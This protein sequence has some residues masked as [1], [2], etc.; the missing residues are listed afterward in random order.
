M[1]RKY[2]S[3]IYT[4]IKANTN[5]FI[6]KSMNSKY[7]DNAKKTDIQELRVDKLSIVERN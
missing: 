7:L 3:E 2:S 1:K 5:H 4:I 6:L